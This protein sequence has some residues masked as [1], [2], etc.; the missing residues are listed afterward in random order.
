MKRERE[1]GGAEGPSPKRAE[2]TSKHC[3]RTRKGRRASFGPKG[4]QQ[5][6]GSPFVVYWMSVPL[7]G[8]VESATCCPQEPTQ[9]AC[10]SLAAGRTQSETGRKIEDT[11]PV[12]DVNPP[13]TKPSLPA[14]IDEETWLPRHRAWPGSARHWRPAGSTVASSPPAVDGAG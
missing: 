14:P 12:G 13:V 6:A 2:A 3:K 11:V 10:R 1:A 5:A 4:V 9:L 7:P 8:P